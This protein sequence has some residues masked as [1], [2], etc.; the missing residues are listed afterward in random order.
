MNQFLTKKLWPVLAGLIVASTAMMLFEFV[1]SFFFPLPESLDIMDPAAVAA[2]T[3]SLP[4]TVYILV[5]LGWV[6]G[7][8]KGGFVTT[9]LS[10]EK[11]YKLSF[12]LGAILTVLGFV[13]VLM[14]GHDMLFSVVSLPMFLL[15]TYLGHTFALKM[16]W[17]RKV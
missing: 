9:Y 4:W 14:I 5:F 2:F 16:G 15:F 6:A 3:A 1:N 17:Q 7:S 12:V 13:N 10:G 11:T 8:F